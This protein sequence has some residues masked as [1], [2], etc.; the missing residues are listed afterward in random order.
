MSVH[1]AKAKKKK[2]MFNAFFSS[3]SS[4]PFHDMFQ[5]SLRTSFEHIIIP[6]LALMLFEC[7][8]GVQKVKVYVVL[9]QQ[10]VI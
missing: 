10:F 2:I 4:R 7:H 5:V 9:F 3:F 6:N 8:K 1:V